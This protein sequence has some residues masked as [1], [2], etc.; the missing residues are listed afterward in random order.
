VLDVANMKEVDIE[1][2]LKDVYDGYTVVDEGDT[3]LACIGVR[4]ID[5]DNAFAWALIADGVGT[6]FFEIHK[7]VTAWLNNCGYPYTWCDVREGFNEGHRWAEMLGFVRYNTQKNY[8]L[9][10][11]TAVVYRRDKL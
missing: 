7:C 9:D 5:L 11:A 3:P 10:G 4:E 2:A 8:Y 6:K 1:E